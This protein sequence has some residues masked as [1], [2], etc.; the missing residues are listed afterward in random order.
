MYKFQNDYGL[1]VDGIVGRATWNKLMPYINGVVR[2][3]SSNRYELS[4]LGNEN[5][6]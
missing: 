3:D 5:E 1:K 4:L 6:Y 2:F